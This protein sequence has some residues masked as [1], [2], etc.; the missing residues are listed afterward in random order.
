MIQFY[1]YPK[2]GTCKKALKW[3]ENKAIAVETIDLIT[4]TPN[5]VTLEKWLRESELP[6]KRFFNTSGM[7][8]RALDL[9]D[10]V[11]GF[12]LEEAAQLLAT[13]GMLIKRPLLIK[14]GHFLTNGFKEKEY[15]GILNENDET[16]F[17]EKR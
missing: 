9:K 12:T 3:L 8:Y 10:K 15:E 14:D 6:V 5:A 16:F 11:D 7:K 1:W 17:K 2:C 13:D 4:E